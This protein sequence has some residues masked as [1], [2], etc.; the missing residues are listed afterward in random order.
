MPGVGLGVELGLGLVKVVW[1]PDT[2]PLSAWWIR[3]DSL[4]WTGGEFLGLGGGWED[5]AFASL[6]NQD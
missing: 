2:G 1:D 5:L 3:N 4:A 6:L